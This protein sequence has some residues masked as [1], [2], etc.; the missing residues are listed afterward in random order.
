MIVYFPHMPKTG[1]Y[2][3][4]QGFNKAFGVNKCIRVGAAHIGADVTPEDFANLNSK[5]F[6]N[7]SA[8]IGHLSVSQFLT[9]SYARSEFEKGN[10]KVLTSVREPIQRLVSLYNYIFYNKN[11]RRHKKI[12]NVSPID[13]IMQEPA[14]YQFN[15]LKPKP[16]STLND[17]YEIMEIFPIEKSLDRLTVFFAKNYNIKI[18]HLEVENKS[19]DWANG[20]KLICL[21]D[22][23]RDALKDLQKKHQ[24]DLDLYHRASDNC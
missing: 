9:N 18:G 19:I 24:K 13:F 15:F 14:N 12:Q 16:E 4:Y 20:K 5:E 21:D 7:I 3:L 6:E 23:P 22:L 17:I 11:H 8:V 10:V 2:S 1:G